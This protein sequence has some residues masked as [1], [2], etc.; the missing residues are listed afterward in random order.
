MSI[1]SAVLIAVLALA[2][3]LIRAEPANVLYIGDS[4]TYYHRMPA[5]V[6]A[7]ARAEGSPREL[8]AKVVAVPGATL[9]RHWVPESL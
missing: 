7:M 1:R 4:Y 8:H 9:K 2:T 5:T 3:G 6:A